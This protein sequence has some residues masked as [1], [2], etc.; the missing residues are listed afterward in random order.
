MEN[1]NNFARNA[2]DN[3]NYNIWDN[4]T[5]GNIWSDYG[6]RDADDDGF[7][8]T[9]YDIEGTAGSRDNFPVW[10]DPPVITLN[11]PDIN[12]IFGLNAPNFNV[13]LVEGVIDEIWYTLDFGL[14]NITCD[15]NGQINQSLWNNFE[16]GQITI[17]FYANDSRGFKATAGI[18]VQK[19][20]IR[21]DNQN[22]FIFWLVIGIISII[23]GVSGALVF[24]KRN[25]NK[26]LN[27]LIRSPAEIEEKIL[28]DISKIRKSILEM[29]TKFTRIEITEINDVSGVDNEE[30]IIT[31]LREMINN[32]EVYAQYFTISKSLVFNQQ[33]NIDEIDRLMEL[34]REW[35][36][37]EIGK[38]K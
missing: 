2:Y 11:S 31:T 1:V 22:N 13:N 16:D 30:L 27:K 23:G 24:Y 19:D 7:G 26:K 34:Y 4:G 14:T 37:K 38:K 36:K 29:S 12:D 25:Q 8:D 35:E 15:L 20:T 18:I 9:P 6:G 28:E 32:K 3:G 21:N 5:F 10:W 17:I 33:A